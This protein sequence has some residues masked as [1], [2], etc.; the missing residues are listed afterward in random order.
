VGDQDGNIS[1]KDAKG[2]TVYYVENPETVVQRGGKSYQ[3][4]WAM[5][6]TITKD[7]WDKT[8]KT[9]CP[10]G[11]AKKGSCSESFCGSMKPS[12]RRGSHSWKHLVLFGV[13]VGGLCIL[14]YGMRLRSKR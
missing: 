11:S 5:D 2:N 6:H 8:P 4:R 10:N 1:K 7:Q 9:F 12:F 13:A 3:T 14:S